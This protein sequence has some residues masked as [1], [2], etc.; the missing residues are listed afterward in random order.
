MPAG[1]VPIE[2][3]FPTQRILSTDQ[4]IHHGQ[5][6]LVGASPSASSS[7][8]RPGLETLNR[9]LP[10]LHF[11]H[12]SH[13]DDLTKSYPRPSEAL[14]DSCEG[15][16]IHTSVAEAYNTATTTNVDQKGESRPSESR[17]MRKLPTTQF[18][19]PASSTASLQRAV[20][21][22]SDV[23]QG[24]VTPYMPKPETTSISQYHSSNQRAKSIP[25]QRG[26]MPTCMC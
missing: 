24:W 9:Y 16:Q 8:S 19:L 5:Y 11:R 13:L 12:P 1:A 18:D 14:P 2:N 23:C 21:Q 10:S 20:E 26:F 7:A 25:K 15:P 6:H 4:A 22:E 3:A 17:T